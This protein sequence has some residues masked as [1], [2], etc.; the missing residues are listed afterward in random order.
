MCK[1]KTLY[2]H[3]FPFKLPEI[4]TRNVFSVPTFNFLI[5]KCFHYNY[6]RNISVYSKSLEIFF[7]NRFF[8]H[9]FLSFQ[10]KATFSTNYNEFLT[11][12]IIKLRSF[13]ISNFFIFSY[14]SYLY[15]IFALGSNKQHKH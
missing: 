9:Y 12:I 3:D 14:L 5:D 4:P 6:P 2:R 10:A 11:A 15:I 7:I 13:F 8:I 1:K